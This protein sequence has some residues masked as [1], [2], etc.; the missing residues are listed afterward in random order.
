MTRGLSRFSPSEN[1]TVPF[2]NAKIICESSLA[3][4]KPATQKDL[5]TCEHGASMFRRKTQESDLDAPRIAY[6]R[7]VGRACPQNALRWFRVGSA[8]FVARPEHLEK[9]NISTGT[10]PL[11]PCPFVL[12][13][14][15]ADATGMS[16][17]DNKTRRMISRI[18]PFMFAG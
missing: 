18:G 1:G 6:L 2:P 3:R 7:Y 9:Q 16:K 4:A 17:R 8:V 5:K 10:E 12:E 15:K 14:G 11:I 13:S